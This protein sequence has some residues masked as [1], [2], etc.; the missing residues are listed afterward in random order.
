MVAK[1]STNV[2]INNEDSY[3]DLLVSIEV[4]VGMLSILIAVCDDSNLREEIITR[5]E[6]ALSSDIR[7][8]KLTIQRGEPSLKTAIAQLVENNEYL[9][10]GGKAVITVTGTEQLYFLKLGA[11]KSE[12]EIF[13]GY[14]QWTREALQE[15]SYPIVLWVTN[16]MLVNL[17]KKAPDF[18]SWRKGV[19]RF[20]SKKTNAILGK[21]INLLGID[22]E[23]QNLAD[24]NEDNPYFLPIEDLKALIAYIEQ[25]RGVED[26]SL[27]T[28]YTRV[29]QIYK[30]RLENSEAQNYQI[31][32]NLAIE[33]FHKAAELQTKLSKS[34]DLA[35]TLNNL[36]LLY[37]AKGIYKRAEFLYIK[38]LEI[39]NKEGLPEANLNIV[40]VSN[41]LA[42]LYRIQGCYREAEDLYKQVIEMITQLRGIDHPDVAASLN[43]LALLYYDTGRYEEAESLYS[44]ALKTNQKSLGEDH[45][46]FAAN[47]NNLAR[48]YQA[49][50]RYEEAEPLYMQALEIRIRLLGKEHPEVAASLNNLALFYYYQGRYEE[51]KPLFLQ[52]LKLGQQL[53]GEKHPHIASTLNNLAL[54]YQ[55]EGHYQE[56]TNLYSQALQICEQ[57]LAVDNPLTITIRKNMDTLFISIANVEV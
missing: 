18:W 25:Q 10:T 16:Q 45:P 24:I 50:G 36:A 20:A 35:S 15:F 56:A 2:E 44:L 6:S 46:A 38:T 37:Q 30:R 4:S 57:E 41:N 49:Q 55:A 52:A 54:I 53:L 5:Y 43:N 8:F 40:A 3:D 42:G 17:S 14:L 32:Q 19:F 11:E 1:T 7:N 48:L 33:Y 51:A 28:L 31:E 13:F 23:D 27:A 21:H 12:Q 34:L 22:L 47:I 29:G 26:P 39:M 9:Q